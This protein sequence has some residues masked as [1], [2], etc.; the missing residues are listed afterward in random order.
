[1]SKMIRITEIT[2]IPEDKYHVYCDPVLLTQIQI[3]RH[4]TIINDINLAFIRVL[5]PE[6][7]VF[8][9][10]KTCKYN[11][12]LIKPVI[13]NIIRLK[14]LERINNEPNRRFN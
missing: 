2:E 4:V 7:D 13:K 6:Y 9:L 8:D 11:K 12:K 1:M 5:Y 10:L 14:K 3:P